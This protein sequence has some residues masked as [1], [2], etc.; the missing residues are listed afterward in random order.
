ML[1]NNVMYKNKDELENAAL[2]LQALLKVLSATDTDNA[3]ALAEIPHALTIAASMAEK[4]YSTV[5]E[6]VEL[7]EV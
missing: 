3:A 1:N 5:V 2:Q 6:V 7:K 4:I